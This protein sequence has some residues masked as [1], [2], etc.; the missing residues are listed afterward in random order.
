MVKQVQGSYDKIKD[1]DQDEKGYFLIKIY[2]EE[3]KLGVR[4]I[5]KETKEPTIDI[6][7]K[8]PQEI[9]TTA[10]KEGLI[11]KL[12]HASYLGKELMKA[13][14]CLKQGKEYIQDKEEENMKF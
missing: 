2:P 14:V 9:Y 3:N 11:T 4:F 6:F 12:S 7:G 5:D 10:I 13:F 8:I 1:W